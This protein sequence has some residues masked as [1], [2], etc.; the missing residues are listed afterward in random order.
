VG[1]GSTAGDSGVR[2][3][4]P[5]HLVIGR[6][7]GPHGVRGEVR[8]EIL[9]DFSE[10]FDLLKTVYV[11]EELDAMVVEGCRTRVGKALLKLKGCDSRDAVDKLRGRLV[12]VPIDE[13]VPLGEDEYYLYEVLGLEAHTVDG[14]YLGHVVEILDTG[15]NDVYI[16]RDGEKEI[17][18]PA[19]SDV[20]TNVDL[21]AGRIEVQLPKGLR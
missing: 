21:E 6:I 12:Q 16:V 13:A 5:T 17:L 15:S 11:G 7:L 9:T 18:I 3:E 20:V 1:R 2:A 4:R 10:R 19:L 14:E 8:V